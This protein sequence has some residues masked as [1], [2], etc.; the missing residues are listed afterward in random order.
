MMHCRL[1]RPSGDPSSWPVG[2]KESYGIESLHLLFGAIHGNSLIGCVISPIKLLM[3]PQM[4]LGPFPEKL[5]QGY[6]GLLLK[7]IYKEHGTQ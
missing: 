2:L 5:T 4:L 3:K 7:F 1:A 6:Q